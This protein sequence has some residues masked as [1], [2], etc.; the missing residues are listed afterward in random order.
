MFGALYLHIP[1]CVRRCRYCD[2]ATAAICHDDPLVAA[3][4]VALGTL[5]RRVGSAGLLTGAR[6]AYLGG[7]TPTMAGKGLVGLVAC[8][9]QACPGLREFSS[10]ANPESLTAA[11]ASS[12]A[13]AGLTRISLGVQSTNDAELAR[14]GRA[15]DR[16]GALA[17]AR[18]VRAVGIDLSCDLMA[19]VPLQTPASWE[20]S[21]CDVLEAGATH[22]SCYPLM[23]ED[24]TPLATAVE[25]GEEC[26][27]DDDLQADLMLAAARTLGVAGL[28]RYEVAS[29]AAPGK[30]C[31]H[32]IAYWTGVPYLGLGSSAAGMTTPEGLLALAEVLPIGVV[33]ADGDDDSLAGG[34][35]PASKAVP[36]YLTRHPEASRIRLR[37]V[38]DAR[39]LVRKVS[40]GEALTCEVEVLTAR[41]AAAEDLMLAM[42]MSAG[43]PAGLLGR[44]AGEGIIPRDALER[45]C[46]EVVREGLAVWRPDGSLVPTQRGWLLGNELYGAMWELA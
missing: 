39:T 31:A 21:L 43:A 29:Y 28:E 22:V 12:L 14:L 15:H 38:D 6:S 27:P 32:N 10:E 23:V 1:F 9:R 34:A 13:Q 35:S 20:R 4:T 7:G 8:V 45:T 11:L 2:F 24:G 19:G 40:G 5:V 16:S 46:S 3:Y 33:D 37:M 26:G 30:A 18:A 36:S 42:R 41:E 17:A 44:A 25:A